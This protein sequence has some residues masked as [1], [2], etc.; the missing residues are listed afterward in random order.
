M[1]ASYWKS[2][3]GACWPLTGGVIGEHA[4]LLTEGVSVEHAG[5]LLEV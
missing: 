5:L 1:L 3:W 4:C 2:D